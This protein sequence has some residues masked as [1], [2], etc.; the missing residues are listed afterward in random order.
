MGKMVKIDLVI[1]LVMDQE[2]L[3]GVSFMCCYSAAR[4]FSSLEVGAQLGSGTRKTKHTDSQDADVQLEDHCPP[5][6]ARLYPSWT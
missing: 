4:L 6:T 2:M 1:D 3:D 5:F